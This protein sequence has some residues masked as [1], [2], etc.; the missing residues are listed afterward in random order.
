MT[1]MIALLVVVL[2]VAMAKDGRD[3]TSEEHDELFRFRDE[4]ND[5]AYSY[6]SYNIFH[7]DNDD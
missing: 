2:I 4:M 6:L 7:S 5:P 3:L 1:Y